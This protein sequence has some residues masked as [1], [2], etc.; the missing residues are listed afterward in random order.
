MKRSITSGDLTLV[1]TEGF[2]DRVQV[3]E[4]KEGVTTAFP[5]K[6][7]VGLAL[8]VHTQVVTNHDPV[9]IHVTCGK[10]WIPASQPPPAMFQSNPMETVTILL[11]VPGY[12]YP[13]PGR[14]LSD[15][16]EWCMHGCNGDA[17]PTHW[18]PM[19]AKPVS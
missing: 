19:P 7:F 14:Y 11:L 3:V 17:S 2:T 16:E 5:A 10:Y 18:L 6:D 4:N 13:Q 15:L 9:S 1:Y 8:A 12:D